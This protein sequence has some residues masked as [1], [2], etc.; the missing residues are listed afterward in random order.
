MSR[1]AEDEIIA[2]IRSRRHAHAES[3]GFDLKL[4]VQDLQRQ[5][6]ESGVEVIE[7]SLES[8]NGWRRDRRPDH[9][10]QPT[11]FAGG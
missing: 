2:E 8:Q 3:F 7:P 11:G 5:E 1:E 9:P 10:L 6:R 4:I